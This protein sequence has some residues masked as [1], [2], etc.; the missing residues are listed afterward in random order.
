MTILERILPRTIEVGDCMEWQG[1]FC[2]GKHPQINL[3][4]GRVVTVRRA[5]WEEANGPVPAG[6]WVGLSCGNWR[7]VCPAHLVARTRSKALRGRS[8]TPQEIISVATAR[9]A[10]SRLTMEDARAMRASDEPVKAL[11][12][13]YRISWGYVWRIR[14]GEAWADTAS[15]WQGLG[16]RTA[17]A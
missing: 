15:P 5:L 9:R 14:R 13:R 1:H 4:G 8:R 6:L 16:G 2:Q 11:A 3:G 17:T 12:A 7:C 10:Q